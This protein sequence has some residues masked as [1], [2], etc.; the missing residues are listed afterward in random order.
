MKE[1]RLAYH[2]IYVS[3]IYIS[4]WKRTLIETR[5]QL[6]LLVH[7]YWLTISKQKSIIT[8]YV[9]EINTVVNLKNIIRNVHQK[10]K[11][12]MQIK[13]INKRIN[14]YEYITVD[15]HRLLLTSILQDICA[16]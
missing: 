2:T 11:K 13:W 5:M 9:H 16:N 4:R 1:T 14:A 7:I 12:G 10:R 6:H 8:I 15:V 3:H